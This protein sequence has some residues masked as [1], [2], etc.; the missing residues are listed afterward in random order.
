MFYA[1]AYLSSQCTKGTYV[2]NGKKCSLIYKILRT[3]PPVI[4]LSFYTLRGWCGSVNSLV[5]HL[6]NASVDLL[7]PIRSADSYK[8]SMRRLYKKRW[9]RLLDS[10]TKF[11]KASI[12]RYSS[13]RFSWNL[14]GR[15]CCFQRTTNCH[16]NERS[17]ISCRSLKHIWK[18]SDKMTWK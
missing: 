6:H 11:S 2:T 7:A 8:V 4:S 1:A 10:R 17:T 3:Y 18:I 9:L 5:S 12:F 14:T 15:N 13:Q 16:G